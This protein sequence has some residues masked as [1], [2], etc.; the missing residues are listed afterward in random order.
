MTNRGHRCRPFSSPVRA[1]VFVAHRVQHSCC[2]SVCIEFRHVEISP[3][4][5]R[6]KTQRKACSYIHQAGFEPQRNRRQGL[7]VYRLP[8][9]VKLA[10]ITHQVYDR[11]AA[12]VDT[13]CSRSGSP[14]R[15]KNS[16][17]LAGEQKHYDF[18]AAASQNN[19]IET[20]QYFRENRQ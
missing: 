6:K 10:T 19:G 5:R 20:V 8:M 9:R 14:L 7:T 16:R 1:F 12:I 11:L 4:R 13:D 2:S 3:C 15:P 17:A 18:S